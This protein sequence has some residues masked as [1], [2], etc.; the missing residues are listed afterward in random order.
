[1]KNLRYGKLALM[2]AISFIIMYAVMFANVDEADHV[3]LSITRFYMV[4]LMVSPMAILM[5]AMMPDMY[6]N[7]LINR[8][9]TVL[10]LTVFIL[11][12]TLLRSQAFIGDREYMKAMIPHH[13]SAILTSKRAN[14]KDSNV[15]KLADSIIISQQQEILRMKFLLDTLDGKFK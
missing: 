9:I 4:I 7:K 1:M 15:R 10:S 6:N 12:L 11:A 3:Y 14:I 5:I 13:S 2:L 8:I